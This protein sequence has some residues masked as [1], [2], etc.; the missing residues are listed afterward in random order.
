[1]NEM[2]DGEMFDTYFFPI[3][4]PEGLWDFTYK[5]ECHAPS[6]ILK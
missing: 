6:K 2:I 3:S 1:M 4:S 5:K